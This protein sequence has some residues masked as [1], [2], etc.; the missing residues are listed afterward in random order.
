[1]F[2]IFLIG[3]GV[4]YGGVNHTPALTTSCQ[5]PGLAISASDVVRGRPLYFA[6]TGPNRTVVVAIDAATL[7]ADLTAVPLAGVRATQVIRPPVTLSGCA[8]KGVLGVQVPAGVH[9]VSV[10]AAE[11]GGPLASRPLTVTDR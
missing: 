10:F 8:G 6:V 7:S 11:G 1:V 9:T 3:S 5:T 4:R 2:V